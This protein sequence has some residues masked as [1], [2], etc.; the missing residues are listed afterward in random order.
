MDDQVHRNGLSAFLGCQEHKL[1]IN[2]HAYM[3]NHVYTVPS[4]LSFIDLSY[5]SA[6]FS[7]SKMADRGS[8]FER[9]SL[10]VDSRMFLIFDRCVAAKLAVPGIYGIPLPMKKD[11]K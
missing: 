10:K 1:F 2:L 4:I 9:E 5:A 6:S 8:A 11:L 7:K 3:H